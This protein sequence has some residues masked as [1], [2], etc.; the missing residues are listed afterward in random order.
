MRRFITLGLGLSLVAATLTACGSDS[1]GS[2]AASYCS[3]IQGL[4]DTSNSLDTVFAGDEA[5]SADGLK[6]AFTTMQK[7]TSDM[8]KGAPS[9][10]KADVATMATGIDA[11]VALFEKYEWDVTAA[12]TSADAEAFDSML[13]NAETQAASDRLDAYALKECGIKTE[14]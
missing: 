13:N 3:R 8:K 14:S 6:K 2:S 10:I 7:M 1:G 9:E 4:E 11:I 12:F 5:P